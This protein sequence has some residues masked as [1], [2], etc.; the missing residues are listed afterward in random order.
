MKK[1]AASAMLVGLVSAR[2]KEIRQQ[3]IC[4]RIS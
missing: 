2:R 3:I 1:V 4:W